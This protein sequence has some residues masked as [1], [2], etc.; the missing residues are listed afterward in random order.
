MPWCYTDPW[1]A[2]RVLKSIVFPKMGFCECHE[3]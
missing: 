3:G 2:W 1:K